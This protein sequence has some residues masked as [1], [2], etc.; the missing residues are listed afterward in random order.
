[1]I[2]YIGSKRALLSEI[3]AAI[4][5]SVP[6][7]ARVVDL[8]CGSARVS[9]ACKAAGF[10]VLANDHNAYAHTLAT[11]YVQADAERWLDRAGRLL[12]EL[13]ALPGRPGYFTETFCERSRFFQP[14]NGERI[15]A[16]R[17][18]I[19]AW[20]LEPELKA[21][22]LVALMEGADRVDSTAGLQMAYMKSWAP[23]SGRDLYLKPP[24]ILPG[25][26]QALCEDAEVLAPRIDADLV[27][28][29]P[30][31]NQHSYLSNYH[32]WESLVRWDKP[33]VYGVAC[34]RSDCR[35]RKSA[36]NGK[37]T[38]LPAMERLIAS[39]D[40]PHLL[41]SFN[42]EGHL[43]RDQIERLLGADRDVQ[44]F[45]LDHVRYA[46]ARIGVF[47]PQGV[48]VGVAGHPNNVEYLFLASR[49]SAARVAA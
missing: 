27:Y 24:Q 44:V 33:D 28:L 12:A 6:A 1:M 19:E 29:D 37:R 10:E 18:A 17:E 3:V 2:K 16:M 42:N 13:S 36:F 46:G 35:E 43:H 34:K 15:D 41:M 39:L 25:P 32:V 40:A 22:A 23:R 48:K 26:G 38:I 4:G 21:I 45:A 5:A 49:R 9:H 31:Y 14:R 47:S 11:C 30:P 8:F 20:G 7:G